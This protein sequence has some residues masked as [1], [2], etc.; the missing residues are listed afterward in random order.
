MAITGPKA[1]AGLI[2]MARTIEAASVATVRE[3]ADVAAKI[4][5]NRISRDSG[6]DGRLSGMNRAKGRAG[7]TKVGVRVKADRSSTKPSAFI[8]ATGPLQLINNDTAGH[9]IR[10]AYTRGRG[11]KGFV[12]PTLPGQ[13]ATT[14]GGS[15]AINIPGVGFRAWARHPGTKGKG[16]WQAGA[17]QAA[18]EIR[19]NMSKRTFNV[20]KGAAKL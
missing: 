16:T 19:K 14:G 13:F 11:R 8:G 4:H 10:S 5:D 1:G 7:N 18:P 2:K 12:G 9:V 20:V 17:K 3:S 6:G 15:G